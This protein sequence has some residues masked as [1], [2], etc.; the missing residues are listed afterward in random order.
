[1]G[2]T[3]LDRGNSNW[4]PMLSKFIFLLIVQKYGEEIKQITITAIIKGREK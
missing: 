4:L 2:S 1:V 3:S